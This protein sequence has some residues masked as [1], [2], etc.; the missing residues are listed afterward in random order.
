M[1][2]ENE[3]I[4][5]CTVCNDSFVE[6]CAVLLHSLLKHNTWFTG[7]FVVIYDE[8]YSPLSA[9]SQAKLSSMYEHVVF[10]KAETEEYQAFFQHW[11]D[12]VNNRYVP[13]GFTYEVFCLNSYDKV[14]FF[15]SDMLVVGD[16]QELFYDDVNIGV[17]GRILNGTN[18]LGILSKPYMVTKTR[19]VEIELPVVEEHNDEEPVDGEE[20]AQT[21]EAPVTEE[22]NAPEEQ[23]SE[24][25]YETVTYNELEEFRI[26]QETYDSGVRIFS[27]ETFNFGCVYVNNKLVDGPAVK[28]K[29]LNMGENFEFGPYSNGFEHDVFEEYAKYNPICALPQK[30]NNYKL[31]FAHKKN[32]ELGDTRVLHYLNEKPW[33]T[34]VEKFQQIDAIWH[35]YRAEITL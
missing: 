26:S 2:N 6:G 25:R 28:A 32:I 19:T 15:D 23:H 24:V 7:D 9:E 11:A 27:H 13:S 1:V 33:N 12:H 14:V 4:A 5:V 20:S 22:D 3:K 18:N 16:I 31:N 35:Q 10:H 17:Y 29:L 34:N 8:T 21:E 30:F